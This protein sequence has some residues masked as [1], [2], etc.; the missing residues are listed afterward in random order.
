MADNVMQFELVSPEKLII[1]KPVAMVTV[2]GGEGDYGVLPGHAPM[3]TTVKAGVFVVFAEENTAASDRIFVAGGFAEVNQ[4]R[5]TVLAGEAIAV[6][7]L[8]RGEL[9]E[10]AKK[11]AQKLSAAS[12]TEAVALHAK[13]A[14]LAAKLQAAA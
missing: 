14:I 10:E 9:E 1:S 12:E 13:Q 11:L 3:I 5:C 4:T 7:D 6:A 8:N 2:P